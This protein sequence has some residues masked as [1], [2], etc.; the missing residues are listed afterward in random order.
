MNTSPAASFIDTTGQQMPE[1]ATTEPKSITAGD[2]L[3]WTKSLPDYPASLFVFKYALQLPGLPRF[4]ITATA[5]GEAHAVVA[6]KVT[7]NYQ[8]GVYIW[9][10]YAE[11]ISTGT[12]YTIARGVLNILPSPL[13][14]LATT[15]AGRML[16]LI[17]LAFEGGIPRG[18]ETTNIDGQELVRIPI[19]HLE[20][21]G[22]KYR[23]RVKNE[24]LEAKA[25]ASLPGRRTIGIQFVKA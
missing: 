20:A 10:G 5:A 18:L 21:L 6:A 7:A 22:S 1:I 15:H 13:A 23:Q 16:A 11:G 8:P 9:I 19:E 2:T 3:A 4:G 14:E 24:Q 17:E 12:R 25:A